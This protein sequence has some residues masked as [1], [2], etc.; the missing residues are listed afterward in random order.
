LKGFF[1]SLKWN[2]TRFNNQTDAVSAENSC[3]SESHL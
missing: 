3:S 2:L 1:R